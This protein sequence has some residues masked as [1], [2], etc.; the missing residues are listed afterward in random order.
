MPSLTD[1]ESGRVRGTVRRWI[2]STPSAFSRRRQRHIA[3]LSASLAASHSSMECFATSGTGSRFGS[4]T[5]ARKF[6]SKQSGISQ[7]A[8]RPDRPPAPR[9]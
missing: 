8:L 1:S 4:P 6:S 2:L 3:M 9:R 7:E 5:D